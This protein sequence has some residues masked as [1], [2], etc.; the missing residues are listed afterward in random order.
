MPRLKIRFRENLPF[1]AVWIANALQ[2]GYYWNRP[3]PVIPYTG[4]IEKVN[5]QHP[6]SV[7]IL[8]KRIGGGVVAWSALFGL[9]H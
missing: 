3:V 4:N 7:A 1:K 5:I 9:A 6:S 8:S 2:I